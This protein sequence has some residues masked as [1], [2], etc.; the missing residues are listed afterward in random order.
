MALSADVDPLLDVLNPIRT[1]ANLQGPID[2]TSRAITFTWPHSSRSS[3]SLLQ[4]LVI[5]HLT[6]VG[7][8]LST[9]SSADFLITSLSAVEECTSWGESTLRAIQALGGP[10]LGLLGIVCH[11]DSLN[12]TKETHRTRE[13]LASFLRYFFPENIL[14]NRIV[15]VDKPEEILVA[16]RSILAKLPSGASLGRPTS[17][18]DGRGRLIAEKIDWED[19][20]LKVTGHVRGGRFSANRLVHLP[21]FGDFQISKI[22]MAEDGKVISVRTIEQADDLTSENIPSPEDELM[23]EQTWPTEEEIASAPA[24]Q[25][26]VG[27]PKNVRRVPVGTSEYQA[28]W[29]LDD[30]VDEEDQEDQEDAPIEEDIQPDQSGEILDDEEEEEMEELKTSDQ[31]GSSKNVHFM[32][33]SDEAE[34]AA[35]AQYRA[36]RQ[37]ERER[38]AKEDEEFPDE[39]DTPMD[40]PARQR[41]ARYRGM[42]SFRT[43]EWD[44]YENLPPEYGKIFAFQGW[45]SMG[46]KLAQKANELEAGAGPGMHIQIHVEQFPRSS[47]EAL[48]SS[49]H[50]TLV[51]FSLLKHEHKYSVMHFTTQ[52]NTEYEGDIKSKDPLILCVG[53]RFYEVRPIWSQPSVRAT[54]NVHKFERYLRPGRMNVGS[55]YLPVTFGS[56]TPVLVFKQEE[57]QVCSRQ[58]SFVGNGT[59]VGSE[60]QR[61]I[62]KRIILSGHPYKVHKKT[63]TIR[64]M[65]FNR[66]DIEYFKPLELKTKK[67]KIGHIKEPL[68]THGYFKAKFDGMIDQMD[69]ICLLLYKRCFP[70]WA[71]SK[72]IDFHRT[73]CYP[74]NQSQDHTLNSGTME[75]DT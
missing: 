19:G 11:L 37:R 23:A 39:I 35:L 36:A 2:P 59:L 40:V 56:T 63:A 38:A 54:N 60:P 34:Q 30:D 32:E 69:T 8:V 55:V 68:G 41:F 24:H 29:L 70:K 6:P 64:Y 52:R 20:T 61:I 13:S 62:A 15:S 43:S 74:S 10:A 66:E 31:A 72:P 67:G 46:R 27:K 42:K 21:F 45:K 9:V 57:E 16:V 53:F 58:I 12:G 5:P 1:A 14:L 4:F 26:N 73:L 51:A 22:T 3:P 33:L 49:P 65:F 47:F 7:Q 48:A 44:P 28:A 50:H 71:T 75:L 18:R 25:K 17:W